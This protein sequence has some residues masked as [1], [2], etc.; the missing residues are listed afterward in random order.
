MSEQQSPLTYEGILELFRQSDRT[1]EK[2]YEE[3][4]RAWKKYQKRQNRWFYAE[5]GD[6]HGDFVKRLIKG[7]IVRLFQE[8][9]CFDSAIVS[10][11]RGGMTFQNDELDIRDSFSLVIDDSHG[12]CCL[13]NTDPN[14]LSLN[15][16][17]QNKDCRKFGGIIDIVFQKCLFLQC[18]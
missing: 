14:N 9:G 12:H 7:G 4:Q 6:K 2:Q 5:F 3:K 8:L 11:S 15:R 10:I 16:L 18:F 13:I 1:Q 17:R